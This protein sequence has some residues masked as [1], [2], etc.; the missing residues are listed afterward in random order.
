M[1]VKI[2]DG[3]YLNSQHIIAVKI[4]KSAAN[5]RFNVQV[6]YTP[7]SV[8]TTG[9]YQKE[10]DNGIEAESYLFTLNKAIGG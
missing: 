9:L 1:L 10:F 6:E 7:N 2:E 3:F 5:G 8:Q 4:K